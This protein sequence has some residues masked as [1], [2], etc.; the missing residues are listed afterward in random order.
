MRR[1]PAVAGRLEEG[2]V[3]GE[4]NDLRNQ[5]IS[6]ESVPTAAVLRARSKLDSLVALASFWQTCVDASGDQRV[7]A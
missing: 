2:L 5:R 6:S 7:G 4:M 3:I 1:G